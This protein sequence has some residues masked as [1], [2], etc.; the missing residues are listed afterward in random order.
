MSRIAIRAIYFP[1]L[2]PRNDAT[3]LSIN[4]VTAGALGHARIVRHEDKGRL[5]R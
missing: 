3:V 4:D 5:G 2:C 1:A